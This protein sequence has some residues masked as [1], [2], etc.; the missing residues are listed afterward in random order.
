MDIAVTRYPN[1]SSG[2]LGTQVRAW[3]TAAGLTQLELADRAQVSVAAVRDLEQ[4]RVERPHPG[5]AG[6]IARVL[7]VDGAAWDAF[8][9]GRL[10]AGGG[11]PGPPATP[12]ALRIC[13]L[14]P[15]TLTRHG[16]D[17]GRLP[18]GQRAV[19]GLLVLA[20]AN[21]VGLG[22]LIEALWASRP[23]ANAVATVSTYISRLRAL[24]GPAGRDDV[25]IPAKDPAGYRL[26]ASAGA[27]D[28]LEFRD[29]V[30]VA[31]AARSAGHMGSACR[32]YEQALRTWRDEPLADV[33]LLREHPAVA[34]LSDERAAVIQEYADVASG[35]ELHDQVLPFLKALA[36]RRPLDEAAHARL[37]IALAGSGRQAEALQRYEVMRRRLDEELGVLPSPALREAHVNVLRQ[38]V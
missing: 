7:S 34:A 21:P 30:A 1:G 26:L 33:P 12:R 3:R 11:A 20:E 25:I 6:R 22:S 35:I 17:L 8:A 5:P 9:S 31:R 13:V 15:L 18:P 16:V 4:G 14:G 19:L 36:T 2:G 38:Q 28:M 27:V 29:L 37:I 23:P 32:T 24:L 10:R